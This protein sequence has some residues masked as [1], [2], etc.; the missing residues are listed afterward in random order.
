MCCL[1]S[2]SS[3]LSHHEISCPSGEQQSTKQ[4]CVAE[5]NKFEDFPESPQ[6]ANEQ[7]LQL[8]W[9][10]L[11]LPS[12]RVNKLYHVPTLTHSEKRQTMKNRAQRNKPTAFYSRI[13]F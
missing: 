12:T 9:F 1:C 7:G 5:E 8:Q 2:S 3:S 13:F 10:L 6:E 11:F 4:H